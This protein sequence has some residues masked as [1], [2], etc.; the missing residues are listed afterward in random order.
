MDFLRYIRLNI[1]W[2]A[3]CAG[4]SLALLLRGYNYL[5]FEFKEEQAKILLNGLKL[6]RD[7]FFLTHGM[8]ST[9]GFPNGP[10]M[11]QLS[12]VIALT[13]GNSPEYFA[14][15]ALLFS[16]VAPLLLGVAAARLLNVRIALMAALLLAGTPMLIFLG[17]NFWPQVFL[18]FWGTGIF[19]L[20]AEAWRRG[21]AR[22]WCGACAL[23]AFTGSI[24]LSAFFLV[25]GLLLIFFLNRWRWPWFVLGGAAGAVIL[26][27]WLWYVIFEWEYQRFADPSAGW[28]KVWH[29]F[30]ESIN[31]FGGGF[32]AEYYGTDWI[33]GLREMFSAPV[34]V[35]L[36]L[37]GLL[38]WIGIVR[39]VV[40]WARKNPVPVPVRCAV[41]MAGSPLVCYLLLGVHVYFFY[42]FLLMPFLC[43]V[44]AWGLDR[45]SANIRRFIVIVW[46]FA[47]LLIAGGSL[48]DMDRGG[49]HP[50]EYGPSYDFWRSLRLD[51]RELETQT[52]ALNVHFQISERAGTRFSSGVVHFLLGDFMQ[53]NGYPILVRIDY[54]PENRQ[55]VRNFLPM[56][57]MY[58]Y[59]R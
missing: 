29:W 5:F 55:F 28:F 50:R 45:I 47:S 30:R 9:V 48:A 52:G 46:F 58:P 44:S 22:F 43:V 1:A 25:P 38:P 40:S 10:G 12:G 15:A 6:A 36:L 8:E 2:L 56:R 34:A 41:I 11:Y 53:Q 20:A 35:V 7:G 57:D 3:V 33:E 14:A 13:G 17:A 42:L 49:G 32:L 16:M 39:T 24:H 54:D 21:D 51:L 19:Y 23:T 37:A 4:G 31:C 27:P 18:P 26:A 59:K